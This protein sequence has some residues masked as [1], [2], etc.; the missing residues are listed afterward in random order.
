[1]LIWVRKFVLY[2]TNNVIG[3][4]SIADL[5]IILVQDIFTTADEHSNSWQSISK[6]NPS[7]STYEEIDT[8]LQEAS[9][10]P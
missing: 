5:I 6:N 3:C 1:M 10:K 4:F 8:T 2:I 7:L 9:Q